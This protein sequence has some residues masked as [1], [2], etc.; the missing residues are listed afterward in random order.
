VLLTMD[1]GVAYQQDA[2]PISVLILSA[3]SNDIDDLR[4]L[5]PEVLRVLNHLAP[6]SI[7]RV[8]S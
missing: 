2:V 1:D 3:A 4:P 5:L 6:R 8:P 7:A